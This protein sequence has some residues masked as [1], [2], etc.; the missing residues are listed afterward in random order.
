MALMQIVSVQCS[1]QA[2][3]LS[4]A[5]VTEV[6]RE[7]CCTSCCLKDEVVNTEACGGACKPA[8]RAAQ[9]TLGAWP[10]A[11]TVALHERCNSHT[12]RR[13]VRAGSDKRNGEDTSAAART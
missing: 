8:P 3:T 2:V 1:I 10:M 9:G 12:R 6:H 13:D 5:V 7:S 4:L 11:D